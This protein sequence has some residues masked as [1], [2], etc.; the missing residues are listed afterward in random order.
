MDEQLSYRYQRKDEKASRKAWML[1]SRGAT[2]K[3]AWSEEGLTLQCL[4]APTS[5]HN[6]HTT[7]ARNAS[8]ASKR[9]LYPHLIPHSLP[10]AISRPSPP[11]PAPHEPCNILKLSRA[12]SPGVR[13]SLKVFK[14]G[15]ESGG[16]GVSRLYQYLGKLFWHLCAKW[17]ARRV[18]S[19]KS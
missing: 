12:E 11:V 16:W 1:E 7:G 3:G 14:W 18:V 9:G 17:K 19:V 8:E 13:L 10:W 15:W 5:F 4:L 6:E 2:Q